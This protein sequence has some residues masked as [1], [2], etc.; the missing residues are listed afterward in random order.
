M[1]T[2]EKIRTAIQ[3][4]L[5]DAKVDITDTTGTQDHFD[6]VVSSD[7]FQGLSRLA[8]HRKVLDAL[9]GLMEHNGGPVHAV[10]IKTRPLSKSNETH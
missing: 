6:L 8:K 9:H 2:E 4:A 7:L 3:E 1:N 10:A 5:S